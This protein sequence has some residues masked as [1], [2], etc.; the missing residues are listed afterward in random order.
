MEDFDTPVLS[1]EQFRE[2]DDICKA[3]LDYMLSGWDEQFINDM[4]NNL[5]KYGRE[6]LISSSQWEQLRRIKEQ[7]A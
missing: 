2:A 4:T 5:G 3:A 1:R 6:T 7:Y